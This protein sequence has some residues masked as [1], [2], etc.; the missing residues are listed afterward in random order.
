MARHKNDQSETAAV[1]TAEE[2]PKPHPN[3]PVVSVVESPVSES[4]APKDED[5]TDGVFAERETGEE[6]A[7]AIHAPDDYFRTHSL[8]NTVHFIQCTEAEFLLKFREKK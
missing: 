3:L 5:F 7:L 2:K 1:E 6:F 4:C 8:K